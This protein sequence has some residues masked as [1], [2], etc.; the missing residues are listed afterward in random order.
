LEFATALVSS[1]VSDLQ[2]TNHGHLDPILWEE[3]ADKGDQLVIGS[4]MKKTSEENLN[5]IFK[6]LREG[7]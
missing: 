4:R 2:I 6:L 5:T 1:G 3:E 7:R